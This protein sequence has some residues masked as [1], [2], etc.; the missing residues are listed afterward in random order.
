[1]ENPNKQLAQLA[2]S[3]DDKAALKEVIARY[4]TQIVAAKKAAVAAAA[5]QAKTLGTEAAKVKQICT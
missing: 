5:A 2:V 4:T 3:V 1:M